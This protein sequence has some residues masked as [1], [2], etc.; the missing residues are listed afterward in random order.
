MLTN[1]DLRQILINLE[2]FYSPLSKLRSMI[3][4][5]RIENH[6]APEYF[7]SFQ[8]C[9]LSLQVLANIYQISGIISLNTEQ[10]KRSLLK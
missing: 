7:L 8:C 2:S 6:Q 9:I 10:T 3:F 4:L 1:I 5:V